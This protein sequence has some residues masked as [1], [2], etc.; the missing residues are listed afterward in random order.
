MSFPITLVSQLAK[1]GERASKATMPVSV[2]LTFGDM[3]AFEVL[4]DVFTRLLSFSK[5]LDQGDSSLFGT[6]L[7]D[8]RASSSAE[9]NARRSGSPA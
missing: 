9:T 1:T 4:Y 2:I 5:S 8:S 7:L 3:L 6:Q